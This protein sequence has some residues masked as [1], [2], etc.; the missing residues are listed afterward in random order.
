MDKRVIECWGFDLFII[1]NPPTHLV[2][3]RR[4]CDGRVGEQGLQVALVKIG[5]AQAP[6]LACKTHKERDGI[7]RSSFFPKQI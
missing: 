5:D 2:D 4:V 6:D 3:A 7:C 1:S